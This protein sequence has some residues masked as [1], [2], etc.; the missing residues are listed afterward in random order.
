MLPRLKKSINQAD[1]ENGTYE[2]IVIPLERELELNSLESPDE[3]QMHTVRHKERSKDNQDNAGII[4]SDTN[5]SNA[6]NY[7]ND[8]KFRTVYPSC[9]TSG[10]TNHSAERCNVGANVANKP[11]PWKSK[12]Q[13]RD[14]QDSITGC[15]W[16][17]AQSLK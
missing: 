4:N 16:A 13:R 7:K 5:D 1:L 8:R 12:P 2:Q 3:T 9:E 6:N 14:A 15:V 10:K 11:L 17:T